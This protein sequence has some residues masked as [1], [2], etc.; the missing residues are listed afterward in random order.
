MDG[1]ASPGCSRLMSDK[2]GSN[3]RTYGNGEEVEGDIESND[4]KFDAMVLVGYAVEI[5][6]DGPCG[7]CHHSYIT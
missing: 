5:F 7:G 6:Q 3:E 2:L 1:S 4:G